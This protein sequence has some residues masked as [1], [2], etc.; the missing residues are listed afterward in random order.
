M[1][2]FVISLGPRRRLRRNV[3]PFCCHEGIF[4]G[5]PHLVDCALRIR[6]D[7]CGRSRVR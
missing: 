1:N 7:L 2:P 6:V 3:A 4:V 5:R